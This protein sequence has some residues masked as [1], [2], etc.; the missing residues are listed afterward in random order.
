MAILTSSPQHVHSTPY[1]TPLQGGCGAPT[2][3]L[4]TGRFPQVS[5]HKHLQGNE[6]SFHLHGYTFDMTHTH[7]VPLLFHHRK[8]Q[9]TEPL[10]LPSPAGFIALLPPTFLQFTLPHSSRSSPVQPS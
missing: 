9:A 8:S 3:D 6:V 7:R 10:H 4:L 5:N 2:A 1:S